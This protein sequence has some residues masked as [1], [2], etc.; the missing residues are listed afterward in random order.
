[1]FEPFVINV[2]FISTL[3]NFLKYLALEKRASNHTVVS[4]ENDL[5]Q[6]ASYIR[7][8]YEVN[9]VEVKSVMVRSWLVS[10]IEEG[11]S[12]N[13]VNRKLSA[14]K[15]FFK[16]NV[17]LGNLDANPASNVNGPKLKKQ[18]PKFIETDKLAMLLDKDLIDTNTHSGLRDWLIIETLYST[19]IR[20][21][22]LID[23]KAIDCQSNQIKVMGK[24]NKERVIPVSKNLLLEMK[25]LE[26]LS[27]EKG[28]DKPYIFLTDKGQKMYP[29]FVYRKVNEYIGLV[30]TAKK[31]SPHVLRHSFATHMLNNGAE[32]N[33]I[34]ELLGHAN[35]S[36]TQVYTHTSIEKLK[37]VYNQAHPR[38]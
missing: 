32:L 26:S 35:L 38:A 2:V 14:L 4:Y 10:L 15:S 24:R 17:R 18:L 29:K 31:K 12:P 11:R 22:E 9:L 23:L 8:N 21:S 19:G 16:Y 1:M 6:F 25:R 28:F 3:E 33:A 13:S 37:S 34:K 20:Q 7:I 5:S 30:S 36:A 27:I